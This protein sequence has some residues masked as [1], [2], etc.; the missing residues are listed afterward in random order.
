VILA[1]ETDA[2]LLVMDERRSEKDTMEFAKERLEDA[3]SNILGISINR[4]KRRYA[5][6]YYQ[7]YYHYHEKGGESDT[8]KAGK[9]DKIEAK[10]IDKHE[11]NKSGREKIIK[12]RRERLANVGKKIKSVFLR[13]KS[14]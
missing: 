2:S 14:K 4:T 1:S 6:Y 13:K 12:E 8:L 10:H 7:Y 11:L 5:K 3:G 9:T